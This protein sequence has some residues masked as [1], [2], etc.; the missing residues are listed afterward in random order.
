[1]LEV[2]EIE[3]LTRTEL[4]QRADAAF[5]KAEEKGPGYLM[6]AQ[7]YMQELGRR[8]D[9]RIAT[10][11]FA[12]ELIVIFLIGLEL[13]LAVVIAVMGSRQQARDV[14]EQLT[15]F[16]KMQTVLS[17]LQ[18]SSAATAQTLASLQST[19]QSMNDRL[20]TQ[21][22]R[23]AQIAIDFVFNLPQNK[24][25]L[26][27]R[28]N[29]D[30][31]IWGYKVDGEP[32]RLYKRPLSIKRSE[33]INLATLLNDIENAKGN[34]LGNLDIYLRD[35]FGNEFTGETRAPASNTTGMS[36]ALDIV[37]RRW[38]NKDSSK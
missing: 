34:G 28:G 11:D 26:F 23:T 4:R 1:M 32:A 17:Q 35:D 15:A 30:L 33:H 14:N 37:Q 5:A 24:M 8:D 31:T 36:T 29:V 16:G 38:S 10:R 21:L 3:K 18:E 25:D 27:N 7:F 19:M 6:E 22:T 20:G 2:K 9:S 12:M 13:A